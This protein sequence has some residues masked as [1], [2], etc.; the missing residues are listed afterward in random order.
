MCE[1][2]QMREE[3]EKLREEIKTLRRGGR[4]GDFDKSSITCYNCGEQ[5]HFK[6]ECPKRDRHPGNGLPPAPGAQSGRD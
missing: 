4:R 5:G 1:T 6:C 3:L 2:S